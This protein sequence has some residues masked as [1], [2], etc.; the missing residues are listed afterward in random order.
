M[1]ES[2]DVVV[3]GAGCAGALASRR[4]AEKGYS[5]VLL[6]RRRAEELGHE[7][8]DLVEM[9]SLRA[10]G[11]ELPS[12]G[13]EYTTPGSLDVVS[14]DTATHVHVSETPFAVVNRRALSEHLLGGAR[15][16]GVRVLNQCI[17][18]GAEIEKGYVTGVSTDRGSFSCRLAIGATGLDRVLCRDIPSG[19]GIPR[20]L[21]TS[22][23]I[24]VYRETRELAPEAA[25]EKVG[26]FQYHVGRFGGYNWTY[27]GGDRTMDIGTGVQDLPE[28]PDPREIVLGFIRSSPAVG[29]RVISREGGRV[30]TRRPLN[31]M[32]T[33]GLM[34]V[35]DAACQATPVIARGVGGALLGASIASET[36]VLAL[37]AGDVST[38]G[39]WSYNY[40]YM[41][42]R[43][44]HQAALDC[45]RLLMQH[46]PEKDFSWS[47]AKGVIDEP[48]ITSALTGKFEV[49]TSQVK[50]RNLLKGLA[51]MPLLVRYE[52]TL[53]LAQRVLE[54]Y[55]DYPVE[56]DAP[57]F[58]DWSQE[59]EFL[60]EDMER[61]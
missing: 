16:A 38:G 20:R 36:A 49:P 24:S 18:N 43:G 3:V 59:A 9:E 15:A 39:L 40:E 17:A 1:S 57:V 21:R 2:C 4:I 47:M 13:E 25:D 45:L 37:E 22:D 28:S 50:I 30:A 27:R 11:V 19:M 29:E 7:S 6:D 52:N 54:H 33:N 32:V 23:Y 61:V 34:V 35:G 46:M 55:R 14:P 31:T 48:E 53:K 8:H 26:L 58:A 60:F 42:A 44:A 5:V 51:A 10:A 41:H 12:P 56:Y